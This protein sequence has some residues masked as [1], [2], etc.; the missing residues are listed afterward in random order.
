MCLY[1]WSEDTWKL[2]FTGSTPENCYR[3]SSSQTSVTFY[4]SFSC[5]D[6]PIKVFNCYFRALILLLLW[7]TTYIFDMHDTW[8]AIPKG[9][10]RTDA[11]DHVMATAYLDCTDHPKGGH[12]CSSLESLRL[13]SHA[14]CF[15]LHSSQGAESRFDLL[16]P[17][18]TLFSCLFHCIPFLNSFSSFLYLPLLWL[19]PITYFICSRRPLAWRSGISAVT[20]IYHLTP[21]ASC[22]PQWSCQTDLLQLP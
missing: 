20:H 8:Y 12:S 17:P 16:Y 5:C 13:R 6:D 22:E 15:R 21:K 14:A 11:P 9:V 3:T 1:V 4:C 10:I 19:P 7:I 2:D 18:E